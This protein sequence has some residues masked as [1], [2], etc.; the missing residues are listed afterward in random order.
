MKRTLIMATAF[1]AFALPLQA[2]D[3]ETASAIFVDAEGQEAGSASMTDTGDGVLIEIEVEGLP[4]GQWVAF[5]VHETGSCDHETDHESAGDHFDPGDA[6][7]GYKADDGPH[8]GDMPNQY[9]GDDG[10]LR[11]QVF[12]AMVTLEQGEE[13]SIRDRSLM[14]HAGQDDYLTQPAG[15][16]GDRLACAVIE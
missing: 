2:Q 13:T 7:H 14:I 8:A 16:A 1:A 15:D 3:N 11:A 12:N 5:H 6:S 10:V 4:A 9:V